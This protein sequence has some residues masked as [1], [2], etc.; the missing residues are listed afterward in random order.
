MIV[1]NAIDHE[2]AAWKSRLS[3]WQL[4]KA[5]RFVTHNRDLA[6]QISAVFPDRAVTVFPHPVFDD[7][8]MPQGTLLR[9]AEME[10]LFFGLVRPYKG[11]DILL[12]GFALSGR[13]D[14]RLT[15]VGEFWQGEDDCRRLIADLGI[16]DRVELIPRFVSDAEAAEYF[17]RADVVVLPYRSVTGSGVIPT[18]YH[19]GRA[20]VASDLPGL[21]DVV[22]DGETGW[23][24]PAADPN[25]LGK[26]LGQLKRSETEVAGKRAHEFGATLSWEGFAHCVAGT[27]DGTAH[28]ASV[29][30]GTNGNIPERS[31]S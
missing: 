20:V 19:Y 16:A 14:A 6:D 15:V 8:P 17:A 12:E 9:E 29:A 30:T 23:L 26:L 4:S 13:K 18:A 21:A 7:F 22:R 24:V 11:L 3:L 31:T 10:F 27:A 28:H 2:A 25:A 5:S 1:H